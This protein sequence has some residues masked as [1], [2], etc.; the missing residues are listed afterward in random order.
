MN[1]DVITNLT[2]ST[3]LSQGGAVQPKKELGKEE[4][5][6]LLMTQL[7]AQDPLNPTDSTE[8]VAQFSQ[9]ASLEQLTNLGEKMDDLTVIAGASNAANAVSLLGKEVRVQGNEIQGP[10]KVFYELPQT[11]GEIKLEVLD[12]NGNVVKTIEDGLEKTSGVHSVQITELPEGKYTV[13]VTAENPIGEPLTAQLSV[14][15]KVRGVSFNGPVPIL[16]TESGKEILASHIVE[17]YE[18]SAST[19]LTN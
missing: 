14:A 13:K 4:F 1:T 7:S 5:L 10:A 9:F 2:N 19:N 15:E 6:R 3:T 8:F 11:A 12:E 17:I 18:P 16:M